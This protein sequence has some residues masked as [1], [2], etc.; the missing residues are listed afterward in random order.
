MRTE[1]NKSV[2]YLLQISVLGLTTYFIYFG[3]FQADQIYNKDLDVFHSLKSINSIAQYFSNILT[4]RILDI[5][6]I[7]DLSLII[8]IRLANLFKYP[9]QRITNILIWLVIC[10]SFYKLLLK[11]FHSISFAFCLSLILFSHP[12]IIQSTAWTLARKHLLATMFIMFFIYN[13]EKNNKLKDIVFFSLSLLSHPIFLF[14]PIWVVIKDKLDQ[15]L[16]FSTI[17]LKR[18][19]L[20]LV[21]LTIGTAN[22]IYYNKVFFGIL[23]YE[24]YSLDNSIGERIL[25]ISRYF[26]QILVPIHYSSFYSHSSIENALGIPIAVLF[27][28]L[29]YKLLAKDNFIKYLSLFFIALLPVTINMTNIF[30]NDTYAILPTISLILIIAHI[31]GKDLQKYK[32]QKSIFLVL[33]LLFFTYQSQKE[34][35]YFTQG[36][37]VYLKN[38][39]EKEQNCQNLYYL[40]SELMQDFKKLKE[41]LKLTKKVFDT[42][43]KWFNAHN[44]Y[45]YIALQVKFLALYDKVNLDR[46]LVTINEYSKIA[47]YLKLAKVIIHFKREESHKAIA[48]LNEILSI[49]NI[50]F[51]DVSDPLIVHLQNICKERSEKECKSYNNLFNQ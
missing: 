23:Q 43:C 8:D 50:G 12:I 22:I 31:L 27:V 40:S 21:S 1:G 34:M 10:C 41:G 29:S 6:P 14:T 37:Y 15:E 9:I 46:A 11:K 51:I 38:S 7:R 30:I 17:V 42:N 24:K 39:Y 3:F 47:P 49:K 35:K 26:Y 36:K 16:K 28:F 44:S 19:Y 32:K 5:Q 25:A 20:F 33:V 2:T 18:Y 48:T 45:A 4:G 13:L